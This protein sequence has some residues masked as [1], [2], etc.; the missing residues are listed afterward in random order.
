MQGWPPF[1]FPLP[2]HDALI[3]RGQLEGGEGCFGSGEHVRG[4][5]V[6]EARVTLPHGNLVG[7]TH[8]H[9]FVGIDGEQNRGD[10][11]LQRKSTIETKQFEIK[12]DGY[13]DF[14]ASVA[15]TQVVKD[16]ALRQLGHF[17]HVGARLQR[18]DVNFVVHLVVVQHEILQ[19]AIPYDCTV[20]ERTVRNTSLSA[21]TAVI[22]SSF[23]FRIWTGSVTKSGSFAQTHLLWKKFESQSLQRNKPVLKAD[24]GTNDIA[25]TH[26]N[27]NRLISQASYNQC[28]L[29]HV[30]KF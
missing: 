22:T 29:L 28:Q 14:V 4:Q 8:G 3:A 20:A 11:G 10:V 7:S 24:T 1:P 30:L 16:A 2:D 12:I 26:V 9:S 27:I 18:G 13:V 5:R 6:S 17:E 15:K 25:D 19:R 23:S 21:L